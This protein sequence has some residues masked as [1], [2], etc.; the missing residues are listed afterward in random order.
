MVTAAT[1]YFHET[2][3]ACLIFLKSQKSRRLQDPSEA[4]VVII[5]VLFSFP[6]F[7]TEHLDFHSIWHAVFSEIRTIKGL[8]FLRNSHAN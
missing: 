8:I 4:S 1:V 3:C 7:G 2:E 6:G 5:I